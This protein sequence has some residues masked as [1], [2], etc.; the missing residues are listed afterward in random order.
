VARRFA[1]A[2]AAYQTARL[3]N[4]VR[5]G[6]TDTCTPSFARLILRNAPVLPPGLDARGLSER[7]EAVQ[8]LAKLPRSALVLGHVTRTVEGRQSAGTLELTL[9]DVHGRWRVSAFTVL[10]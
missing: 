9:V 1:S 4:H 2:N 7:V 8:P 3:A 6:I 5:L 10:S